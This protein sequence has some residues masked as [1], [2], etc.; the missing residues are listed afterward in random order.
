MQ[1]IVK[2]WAL[3]LIVCFALPGCGSLTPQ[4][5]QQ[6]AYRKHV[7]KVQEVRK[8]QLAKAAKEANRPLREPPAMSEPTQTV[9]LE[10]TGSESVGN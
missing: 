7:R 6:A 1:R 2:A 9:T 4:G 5:R 10:S 8:K 3:M